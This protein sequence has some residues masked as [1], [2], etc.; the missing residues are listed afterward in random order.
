MPVGGTWDTEI[1][2]DGKLV[3]HEE[4]KLHQMLH[5][6]WGT[7]AQTVDKGQ[8]RT[9]KVLGHVRGQTLCMTYELKEGRGFE[10]GVIFLTVHTHG[11]MEGYEIEYLLE[12]KMVTASRYVWKP[13]IHR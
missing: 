7:Q 12:K 10:R 11:E 5:L 1:E 6:V 3:P 13:A 8:R 4:V 9:Y 2:R